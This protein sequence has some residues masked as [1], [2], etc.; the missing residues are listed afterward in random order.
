V[1]G[2]LWA[3]ALNTFREAA[4]MRVLHG[5]LVLT[6]GIN[7]VAIFLG[8]A[9]AG[10]AARVSRDFGLASISLAGALTAI[11]LGVVMLYA[12]IQKRTVHAI[13]SKPIERWEF[14]L[15]KYLG[16]VVTLSVMVALWSA[17]MIGIL[18]WQG[19]AL[20][21]TIAKGIVLAWCEVMTVAAIAAYFSSF[22]S[23]FLAGIFTFGVFIAGRTTP[24]MTDS[25]AGHEASS[26]ERGVLQT[27]LQIVPDL[28]VYAPSGGTVDGA[29]V[30]INGAFVSWGY[31]ASAAG[32]GA[33][34]IAGLLVIASVIFQ[35]R[36]FA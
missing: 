35:K 11:Y 16:M 4:R 17:T 6:F 31:V 32:Y 12:E 1:I 34:W 33:L 5:A 24:Y 36:D 19:L 27:A 20:D 29:H 14:V 8:E 15:G 13:V 7:L 3:I 25:L 9:S 28:H 30:T 22:A 23:P 18:A 10:N 2:R 21:A 26:W